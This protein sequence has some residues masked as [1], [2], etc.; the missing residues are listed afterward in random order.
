MKSIK[1]NKEDL[2]KCCG[3]K[4]WVNEMVSNLPFDSKEK[5]LNVANKV[6]HSLDREDWLE[7]FSHHP[8]IGD[9]D[10]LKKR[11]S[12][13]KYLAKKEQSGI[14]KASMQCL[15]EFAKYNEEYEKKFGYIFIICASGK[16]ADEMLALIKQRIKNNPEDEIKIAIEE[17][18][19]ITKLR[20]EKFI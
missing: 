13:T 19:K 14:T 4:N 15:T 3:S 11:F 1:L 2:T 18:N 5:L 12:S 6:W 8:K 20:L 16:S 17:Q 9:V 10:S 7:A